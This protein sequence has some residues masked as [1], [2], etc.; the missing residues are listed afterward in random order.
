MIVSVAGE[1]R[2]RL[3][4]QRFTRRSQARFPGCQAGYINVR[5]YFDGSPFGLQYGRT[6]TVERPV[7]PYL[8]V[9]GVP[10]VATARADQTR[11]LCRGELRLVVDVQSTDGRKADVAACRCSAAEVRPGAVACSRIWPL[12]RVLCSNAIHKPLNALR[13]GALSSS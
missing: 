10:G 5:H 8:V 4:P 9:S 6:Q 11:G 13:C 3:K 12:L 1:D 7:L 2:R